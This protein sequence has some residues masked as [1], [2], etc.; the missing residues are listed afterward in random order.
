MLAF[1]CQKKRFKKLPAAGNPD[2][3]KRVLTSDGMS[4]AGS[5]RGNYTGYAGGMGKTTSRVQVVL[6]KDCH[7]PARPLYF[8]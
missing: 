6:I 7:F 8:L 4:L 3:E 2:M 5:K 1:R